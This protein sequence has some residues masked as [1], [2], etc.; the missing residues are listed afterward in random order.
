MVRS[1]G[2][3]GLRRQWRAEPPEPERG[4]WVALI[5]QCPWNEPGEA[6]AGGAD[7]FVWRIEARLGD[8]DHR[9]ELPETRLQGPWRDLVTEVQAFERDRPDPG[10][11]D[12][13]PGR[14]AD[15]PGH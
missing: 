12:D 1:G 3:A 15:D 5:R 10:R 14:P 2:I 13:D 11:P 8:D 6:D 4:H 7:R 9:T